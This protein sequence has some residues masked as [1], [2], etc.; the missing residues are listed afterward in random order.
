MVPTPLRSYTGDMWNNWPIPLK[1][2]PFGMG[3]YTPLPA[4]Q[5]DAPFLES[6]RDSTNKD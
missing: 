5:Q 6:F 1:G 2:S 4:C 3:N